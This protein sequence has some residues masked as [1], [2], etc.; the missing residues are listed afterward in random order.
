MLELVV[1]FFLFALLA[2]LALPNLSK[3]YDSWQRNLILTDIELSI[4]QLGLRAVES[5]KMI[6]LENDM[7]W[8]RIALELPENVSVSVSGP[9]YYYPNGVCSGGTLLITVDAIE[10]QYELQAPYCTPIKI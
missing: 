9:I 4:N 2:G 10:N 5:H 6:V 7:D 8:S 3:A 1:V